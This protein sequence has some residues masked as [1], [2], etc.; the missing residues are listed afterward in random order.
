MQ[1][2]DDHL[3]LRIPCSLNFAQGSTEN[4]QPGVNI[5][6]GPVV[7]LPYNRIRS[8]WAELVHAST[9]YISLPLTW[10][11]SRSPVSGFADDIRRVRDH[12]LIV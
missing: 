8:G 7:S 2:Q 1:R 11:C 6:L 5:G 4:W 3:R 9:A 10:W 12:Y